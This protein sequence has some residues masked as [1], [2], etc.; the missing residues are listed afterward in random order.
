[1]A[2]PKVNFGN[3]LL[4]VGVSQLIGYGVAGICRR[5]LVKPAAMYWPSVLPNVALFTALNGVETEGDKSTKYPMSRYK[6]FWLVFFGMFVWHWIPGFFA[7]SLGVIS[8]LCFLTT[9]KTVRFLGSTSPNMGVGLF[10]FSFDWANITA[11][12]SPIATP[13][14]A[15]VNWLVGSITWQWIVIPICYYYNV[16][17]SPTLESVYSFPDKTPFGLL[18]NNKIYNKNGSRVFVR[19]VDPM[20]P[21]SRDGS[22]LLAQDFT[23]DQSM[24][25][26]HHPFYLSAFFVIS[27]FT[28]F[29]N[30]ATVVSH[31]ALW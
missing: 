29:M 24:Y 21:D 9:N 20:R 18:N 4:W 30:I 13:W 25:D 31:V 8:I 19:R 11:Q 12:N 27:Y 7:T 26:I 28:S 1:M 15:T 22:S 14:W 6:M 16:W 23:M 2:D 17:G 3:A 10:S 5:F